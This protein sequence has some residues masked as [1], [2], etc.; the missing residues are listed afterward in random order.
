MANFRKSTFYNV[1]QRVSICDAGELTPLML[2]R[3]VTFLVTLPFWYTPMYII[4]ANLIVNNIHTSLCLNPC[5]PKL[6]FS[7]ECLVTFY[8][9]RPP[10][11]KEYILLKFPDEIFLLGCGAV[12]SSA[13]LY[14][15]DND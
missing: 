12:L 11:L 8:Q 6:T 1:I 7:F 3:C 5:S 15:T 9:N 4:L 2:M 14:F 10:H 13:H